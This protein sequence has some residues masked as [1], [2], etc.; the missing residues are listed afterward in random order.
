MSF[1]AAINCIDGRAHAAV[2]EYA[3]KRF[4]VRWVDLI[5]EPGPARI[6]ADNHDRALVASIL[7]RLELSIRAHGVRG[8]AVAAHYG[9]AA[10]PSDERTQHAQLRKSVEL[11][12]SRFPA[13]EVI[14]LWVDRT[15][16]A[17][18]ISLTEGE[19][20]G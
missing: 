17:H 18:E 4:R 3:K 20:T 14:A 12:A 11:L 2:V 1:C 10:N 15:W 8:V 6:L 9:C 19:Q 7:R 5:T 13:C 16:T